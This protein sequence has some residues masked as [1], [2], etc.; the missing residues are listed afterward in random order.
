MRSGESPYPR[1]AVLRA[2]P[3]SLA[4]ALASTILFAWIADQVLDQPTRQFDAQVRACVHG[5]ATPERT[6]WM[7]RASWLGSQVV[8]L[9]TVCL[10]IALVWAKRFRMAA[11]FGIAMAGAEM[12]DFALKVIFHRLRPQPFFGIP[13]PHS[14][15]FPSGHALMS[16]C[17][18]SMVAWMLARWLEQRWQRVV[19]WCAAAAVIALVGLSRIYLGVHYPSDVLVGYARAA[20]WMI[21]VEWVGRR[22]S[23][24]S[25]QVS[26]ARS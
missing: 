13:P 11:L 24:E 1:R 17:F 21:A 20:V 10:V 19:V 26:T 4:V 6:V 15:A 8:V 7:R 22:V 5:F 18:Y 2:I 25:G 12:L 3:L 9:G 23:G 14:Y 16:F